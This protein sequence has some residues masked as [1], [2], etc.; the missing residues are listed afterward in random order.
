VWRIYYTTTVGGGE[1]NEVYQIHNVRENSVGSYKVT[2]NKVGLSENL[3]MCSA[4]PNCSS[5]VKNTGLCRNPN[6]HNPPTYPNYQ[7]TGVIIDQS[8]DDNTAGGTDPPRERVVLTGVTGFIVPANAHNEMHDVSMGCKHNDSMMWTD[9]EQL[10]RGFSTTLGMGDGIIPTDAIYSYQDTSTPATTGDKPAWSD[11]YP[12]QVSETQWKQW[13]WS[14]S[15]GQYIAGGNIMMEKGYKWNVPQA[16]ND[17]DVDANYGG[18]GGVTTD[19]FDVY[20]VTRKNTFWR[21]YP[22][23]GATPNGANNSADPD[24]T[25]FYW[26]DSVKN[27]VR[28]YD[29]DSYTGSEDWGIV[30]WESRRVDVTINDFSDA[31]T[32]FD[33]SV[34][35]TNNC[36]TCEAGDFNVIALILDMD[37]VTPVDPV[38]YI[39]G[40]TVFPDVSTGW[41]GATGISAAIQN[42]GTLAYG[43]STTLTW[44]NVG[45]SG[46][47][48]YKLWCNGA[49]ATIN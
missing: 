25:H 42:T 13:F 9:S 17:Y 29:A 18:S 19:T 12:Y 24:T 22:A 14:Y 43:E 30:E 36:Q 11:G 16:I 39:N 5:C 10:P 34:T 32:G 3:K 21:T 45:S 47:N 23:S 15:D 44:S 41:S 38:P 40:K 31:G 2:Y 7:W 6:F 49:T 28:F 20:D 46:A 27:Y 37:A 26:N 33:I 48:T 8:L 1:T 35:V 4:M